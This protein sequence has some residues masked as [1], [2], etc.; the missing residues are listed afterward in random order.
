M[1]LAQFYNSLACIEKY[2]AIDV[3]IESGQEVVMDR[4][5]SVLLLLMATGGRNGTLVCS[6]LLIVFLNLRLPLLAYKLSN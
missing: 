3:I 2:M 5:P 4:W 6:S 1:P